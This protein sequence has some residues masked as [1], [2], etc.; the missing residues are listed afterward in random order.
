MAR[1][2]KYSKKTKG[3]III[4]FLF[5]VSII[6]TL[7]FTLF[8]NLKQINDIRQEKNSLNKEKSELLEVQASLESDIEKLSDDD[9]IA[10]YAR[11]KFSYSKPGELILRIEDN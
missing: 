7:S 6:L 11:E 3:R 9:Y 4:V 10:R 1:R 8:N 5:F 2:R